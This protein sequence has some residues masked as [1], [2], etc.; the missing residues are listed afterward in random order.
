MTIHEIAKELNITKRAIKFYEE[1]GLL[2]IAKEN[3]GYRNYTESDMETLRLISIYRKLGISISDIQKL[4]EKEDKDILL[5]ILENKE[6]DLRERTKEYEELKAFITTGD[7]EKLSEEIQYE[8]IAEAIKD[9]VPGFY[10]FYFLHHF[11]PYLQGRI[12][13]PEQ[14][15]A[16]D[17]IC[18]FWDNTEIRIPILLRL[19]VWIMYRFHSEPSV[20]TVVAKMDEQMKLY[21]EPDEEQYEKLK[22]SILDGYRMNRI[23]RFHPVYISKRKF[24]KE[25]Q[26]KG[27]NDI[28]IPNMRILSPDYKKYCDALTGMNQ[29]LCSELGL[30]YDANYN[31]VRKRIDVN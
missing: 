22:K 16:Y 25:M 3:N 10:G 7:I 6:K 12:E 5:H 4:L 18:E 28:F 29:R 27:Y 26:D 9:A 31:L 15:K 23:M 1:K 30:Y 20:E 21:L 11:Q 19:S 8:T 24:M 14:K 13:T 2:K 17:I